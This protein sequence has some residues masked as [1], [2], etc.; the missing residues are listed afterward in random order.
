MISLRDVIMILYDR[1]KTVVA[2]TDEDGTVIVQIEGASYRLRF[3]A[4]LIPE[5]V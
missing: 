5:H 3:H 1:M 4:D 2:G